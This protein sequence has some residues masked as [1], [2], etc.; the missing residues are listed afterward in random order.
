LLIVPIAAAMLSACVVEPYPRRVVYAQPVPVNP[1][2]APAYVAAPAGMEDEYVVDM[3][4][5]APNVE[6]V[7]AIPFAGAIWIG[8]YWGWGGGRHYW[9]P[10]RYEHARPGYGWRP[11]AWVQQ[12]GRWHLR[13]GGWERR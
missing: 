4:P 9:V 10:G 6:V 1:Q 5:P 2:P 7:P 12:G 3:A 11:H 8:G 13:A